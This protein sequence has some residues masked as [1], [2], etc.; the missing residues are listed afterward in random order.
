MKKFGKMSQLAALSGKGPIGAESEDRMRKARLRMDDRDTWHHCLNRAAGT[1]EDRP[2]GPRE[3]QQFVNY[4]LQV[5]RLYTVKVV[6]YQIM[7][8]HFHLLLLA[9]VA[10]PSPEETCRR[11]NAFYQGK[12][13]LKPESRACQV[14]QARCRD[15]SWFMRHLQQMF[16]RWFNRTRPVPRRGT[17]WAD[18]FKN[19]IVQAGRPL[20]RCWAYIEF[21][22]VRAGIVGNAADYRFCT[23]GVWHQSGRHPFSDHLRE[24]ALPI[25]AG[26][27]GIRDVKAIR[28][29]MDQALG[30]LSLRTGKGAPP[31]NSLLLTIRRRV[32]HWS[33]GVIIGSEAFVRET[34]RP[35][36]ASS[37]RCKPQ[38]LNPNEESPI[39]SWRRLRQMA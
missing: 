13:T 18:R 11:F 17:L 22:P 25:L 3:K 4:L 29:L 27:F 34:L 5:S 21:N 36:K 19:V 16:T 31:E 38:V 37:S 2:F 24:E 32:R 8:N 39:V 33:D 7:S 1:K 28:S 23:H 30:D 14:W 6:S 26:W 15:V 10:M 12:K 20:W 9:P 35:N